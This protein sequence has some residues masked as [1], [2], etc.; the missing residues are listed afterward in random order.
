MLFRSDSLT[1]AA[2]PASPDA[3]KALLV[4]LVLHAKGHA[5]LDASGGQPE[6][7]TLALPYLIDAD[8]AFKR[9]ALIETNTKIGRASCRERV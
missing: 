7:C 5:I 8:T 1:A 4:G 3:K 9:P 2:L 6:A